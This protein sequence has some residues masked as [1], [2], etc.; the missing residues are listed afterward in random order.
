MC[1]GRPSSGRC[2]RQLSQPSPDR[3]SAPSVKPISRGR[4]AAAPAGRATMRRM[5][6]P[7]GRCRQCRRCGHDPVLSCA[8][9][10]AQIVPA[11]AARAGP[12]SAP[13]QAR[14]EARRARVARRGEARRRCSRRWHPGRARSRSPP[15]APPDRRGWRPRSPADGDTAATTSQRRHQR[16]A[17]QAACQCRQPADPDAV[18]LHQRPGCDAVCS[19]CAEGSK[20]AGPPSSSPPALDLHRDHA[21]QRQGGGARTMPLPSHGR[22]RSSSSV[23]AQRARLEATPRRPAQQGGHLAQLAR[24][25]PPSCAVAAAGGCGTCTVSA[26]SAP[27]LPMPRQQLPPPTEPAEREGGEERHRGH[28]QAAACGW[29]PRAAVPARRSRRAANGAIGC[30]STRSGPLVAVDAIRPREAP[31]AACMVAARPAGPARS[32]SAGRGMPR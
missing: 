6:V 2:Q 27:S 9:G 20:I 30:G 8:N 18:I 12:A 28:Q 23:I 31:M 24:R 5:A 17:L 26:D 25:V 21:G 1:C 7:P 19:R 29:P 10:A 32:R 16:T 3:A 14:T 15:A 13:E 11:A 4:P 22:N